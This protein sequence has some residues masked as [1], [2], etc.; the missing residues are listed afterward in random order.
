MF[1][2]L[3]TSQRLHAGFILVIAFLLVLGSNRLYHRH[4]STL[5]N[6]VNS[7][8]KDRVQVQGYIYQLNNIFHL[9][10]LRFITEENFTLIATENEKA[11]KLL[12][13]FALT[14][15]TS[16]EYNTL[17]ELSSQFQKLK[18][19]EDK[20]LESPDNLSNGVTTLSLQTLKKINKKLDV[21]ATIQLE[22]S[23]QMTQL[24]NKALKS[25][26]L[27]SKLSLGFLILI[28]LALLALIFYPLKTKQPVLD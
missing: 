22:E 21:L 19:F 18:I 20:A 4:F 14:E 27:M 13:E 23:K 10:K 15:L 25:N 28:G 16:K 3:K 2:K 12:S 17:N 5:Q 11:E 1:T 26:L 24:S 9:K 8:Y 6:T 7:V